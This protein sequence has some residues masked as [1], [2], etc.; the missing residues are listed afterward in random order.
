MKAEIVQLVEAHWDVFA[1]G[2]LRKPIRGF[3]FQVDTGTSKPVC[4]K[5]PRY[6]KNEAK[7]MRELIKKLD[8]NGIIEDDQSPWG[9]LVVL[10]S[11]PHQEKVDW[12]NFRWR[13]CVSYRRLN[14]VTK[15]FAF[16]IPR[17][18]DAVDAIDTEAKFF[19]KNK[20]KVMRELIKKLDD[21]GIIEDDQGP[22]GVL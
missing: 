10:A 9:A 21:N 7:V 16:P 19:G 6:G 14:Q 17:C 4:C 20:A 2:G 12:G 22:W 1:E 18:D 8:D 3:E 13:L 15:P 11:K 5:V